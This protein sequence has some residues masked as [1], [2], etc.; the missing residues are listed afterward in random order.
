MKDK[1]EELLHLIA[2]KGPKEHH[3]IRLKD[4]IPKD[5]KEDLKAKVI[6][7]GGAGITLIK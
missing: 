5:S 4:V 6:G 2:R 7:I 3:S 1:T